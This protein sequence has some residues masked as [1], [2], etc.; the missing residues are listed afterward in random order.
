MTLSQ[1]KSPQQSMP[2]LKLNASCYLGSWYETMDLW[3]EPDPWS[4]QTPP[5]SMTREHYCPPPLR[6][7]LTRRK[8][9]RITRLRCRPTWWAHATSL[10]SMLT[11]K[12][13]SSLTWKRSRKKV[14][15]KLAR[16]AD[17]ETTNSRLL[18]RVVQSDWLKDWIRLCLCGWSVVSHEASVYVPCLVDWC[19]MIDLTI[20]CPCCV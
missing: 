13:R 2:D 12:K 8:T 19:K 3:W 16:R 11:Y 15:V 6:L 1:G 18:L 9:V 14:S 4:P 20:L 5:W 10:L 17:M 7:H